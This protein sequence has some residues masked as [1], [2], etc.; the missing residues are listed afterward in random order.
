[1]D[2]WLKQFQQDLETA[3]N[4][5]LGQTE[6]FLD[7]LAEQAAAVVSPMLDAAD[8][9]ADELADQVMENVAP[10]IS[11]ALDDFEAQIDPVV[12]AAV[13]WCEQTMAPLHQTLTP[14]L[15]NHPKCAGCSYYHGESY[16]GEMLVCALH[17]T[18]PE[19]YD[20]CPDWDSVWPQPEEK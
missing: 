15:Q 12:G 1:M 11:Q 19:D 2:D 16:G 9:L 13:T 3:V 8:E 5:T 18:G 14:W 20:V 17:P 10:P 6:Q 4:A 7:E